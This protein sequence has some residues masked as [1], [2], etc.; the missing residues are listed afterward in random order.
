VGTTIRSQRAGH[1]DAFDEARKPLSRQ[2]GPLRRDVVY[3][4]ESE[5]GPDPSRA[6]HDTAVESLHQACI[7][8]MYVSA[9]QDRLGGT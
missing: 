3:E 8:C 7:S 9:R 4:G 1:V 5:N 2:H 6:T